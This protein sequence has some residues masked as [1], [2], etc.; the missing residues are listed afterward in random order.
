MHLRRK[1]LATKKDTFTV[2]NLLFFP[3]NFANGQPLEGSELRGTLHRRAGKQEQQSFSNM[4]IFKTP[5]LNYAGGPTNAPMSG[6]VT[7]FLGVLDP[8][9]GGQ[10]EALVCDISC[11]VLLFHSCKYFLVMRLL[12][13]CD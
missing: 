10:V 1:Q 9:S 8:D 13:P 2:A 11:I 5:F 3:V 6:G 7:T 4:L 12:N